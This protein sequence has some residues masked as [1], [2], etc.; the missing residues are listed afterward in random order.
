[1][2][3]SQ[4][5][6]KAFGRCPSGRINSVV[7]FFCFFSLSFYVDKKSVLSLTRRHYLMVWSGPVQCDMV[8]D[9]LKRLSVYQD[10]T[11][12]LH[13]WTTHRLGVIFRPEKIPPPL[14]FTLLLPRAVLPICMCSLLPQVPYLPVNSASLLWGTSWKVA[15]FVLTN[16]WRQ[17]CLSFLFSSF[18][19]FF[20][21]FRF[22]T[23]AEVKQE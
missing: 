11:L 1:M 16:G 4:T 13:T 20:C 7:V 2:K 23:T 19:S 12:R 21:S 3:L 8:P 5:L 14:R 10:I 6:R 15:H 17:T 18:A 9:H 22:F